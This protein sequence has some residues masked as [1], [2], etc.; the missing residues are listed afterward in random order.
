MCCLFCDCKQILIRIIRRWVPGSAR[1][2]Q[3]GFGPDI[4]SSTSSWCL[5][6]GFFAFQAWKDTG[7]T[8]PGSVTNWLHLTVIR[9]QRKVRAEPLPTK[10]TLCALEPKQV[11]QKFFWLLN[12]SLCV[13]EVVFF[14]LQTSCK[15]SSFHVQNTH[16]LTVFLKMELK[17]PQRDERCW[18]RKG[19]LH[20]WSKKP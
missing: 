1:G 19:L 12:S 8:F 13:L 6:L 15:L 7:F 20:Y 14:L 10:P 16:Q 17:S 9:C 11:C 18:G 5:A 4:S 3:R 2:L